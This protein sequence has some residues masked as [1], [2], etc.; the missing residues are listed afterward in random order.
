MS[1]QVPDIWVAARDLA[2]SWD[3]LTRAIGEAV[4]EGDMEKVGPLLEERGLLCGR[5][6]ELGAG[7]LLPGRA[8][9]NS[10]DLPPEQ[11]ALRTEIREMIERLTAE[12]ARI[13]QELE[14]RMDSLKKDAEQLRKHRSAGR[15]Y[16]RCTPAG[17]GDIVD[18]SR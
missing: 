2:R 12:D 6:E 4:A 8:A 9:A 5:L 13:I 15:A 3:L 11:A 18:T 7:S 16:G 10:G 17:S 14:R 1:E